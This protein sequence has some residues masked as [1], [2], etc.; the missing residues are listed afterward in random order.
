MCIL[1][2]SKTLMY[3]FHYNYMVDK[4]NDNVKLLFTNTDSLTYEIET[5]DVHED[6]WNDRQIR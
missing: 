6:F 5:K 2:L 1:D 3:V 4:Y